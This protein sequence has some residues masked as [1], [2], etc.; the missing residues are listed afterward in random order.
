MLVAQ[1]LSSCARWSLNSRPDRGFI[2]KIKQ[3]QQQ[4]KTP[5]QKKPEPPPR[6]WLDPPA[7]L[8]PCSLEYP[9]IG[10]IAPCKGIRIPGSGKFLLMWSWIRERFARGI[11]NPGLWNPD[12]TQGIRNPTTDWNVPQKKIGIQNPG[13]TEKDWNPEPGFIR[14]PRQGI[15]N[16]RLSWSEPYW[17]SHLFSE[18]KSLQVSTWRSVSCTK[19]ASFKVRLPNRSVRHSKVEMPEKL[20]NPARFISLNHSEAKLASNLAV[21]SLRE[22]SLVLMVFLKS[23]CAG[24]RR[25]MFSTWHISPKID[26]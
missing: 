21:P 22:R 18:V 1:K 15:H 24:R 16:P 13:S 25:A 9:F 19:W 6:S 20:G 5:S 23:W 11:L 7:T 8:L 10:L 26:R 14:N 12:K 2:A 4:T 3:Q 17:K